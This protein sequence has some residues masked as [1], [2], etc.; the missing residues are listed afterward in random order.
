MA[1]VSASKL[2][3]NTMASSVML[4]FMSSTLDFFCACAGLANSIAAAAAS[5]SSPFF[6]L[7]RFCET[8]VRTLRCSRI[9]A[10]AMAATASLVVKHSFLSCPAPFPGAVGYAFALQ[11]QK[12]NAQFNPTATLRSGVSIIAGCK[13]MESEGEMSKCANEASTYASTIQS[14][15]SPTRQMMHRSRLR[16]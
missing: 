13:S 7:S 10:A 6:M 12:L 9:A 2:S 8:A 4:C 16:R 3:G 1:C 11:A 15:Y 14:R 5:I